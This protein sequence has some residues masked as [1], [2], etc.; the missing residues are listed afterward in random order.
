[1]RE[2]GFAANHVRA[3]SCRDNRHEIIHSRLEAAPTRNQE[4]SSSRLLCSSSGSSSS[5]Y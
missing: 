1:M 2:K 3:A 5:A 4:D